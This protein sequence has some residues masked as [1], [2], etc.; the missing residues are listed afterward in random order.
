MR[1]GKPTPAGWNDGGLKGH[2]SVLV[3]AGTK[4]WSI[5]HK[6]SLNTLFLP[7]GQVFLNTESVAR[8][9]ARNVPDFSKNSGYCAKLYLQGY[10]ISWKEGLYIDKMCLFIWNLTNI[11]C[12]FDVSLQIGRLTL[13]AEVFSLCIHGILHICS[14]KWTSKHSYLLPPSGTSGI[15]SAI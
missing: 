2:V 15:F 9:S 12:N 1:A 3:C 11:Q 4:Q 13:L 5:L 10:V 14:E 8:T 7:A 6:H